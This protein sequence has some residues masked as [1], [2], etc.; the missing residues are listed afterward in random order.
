MSQ[1]YS[2]ENTQASYPIKTRHSSIHKAHEDSLC[3]SVG[4]V[5]IDIC[6]EFEP[7]QETKS[8][9]EQYQDGRLRD[10]QRNE[11][12][13]EP[14]KRLPDMQSTTS[15][16]RSKRR[17]PDSFTKSCTNSGRKRKRVYKEHKKIRITRTRPT[18]KV[19]LFR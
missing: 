14:S 13:D 19:K 8:D 7:L 3:E 5:H 10:L 6:G 4:K 9:G 17:Q 15:Y 2:T 12:G 11:Q 1:L 16:Q 18:K